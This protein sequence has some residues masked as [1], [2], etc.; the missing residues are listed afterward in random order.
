MKHL[1]KSLKLMKNGFASFK[2]QVWC[3][4]VWVLWGLSGLINKTYT[5][6]RHFLK[7]QGGRKWPKCLIFLPHG[8]PKN[9]LVDVKCCGPLFKNVLP[10]AARSTLFTKSCEHSVKMQ[11]KQT[12][13][14][15]Q[16]NRKDQLGTKFEPKG[17]HKQIIRTFPMFFLNS[18][19]H[20]LPKESLPAERP[21]PSGRGRGR[22]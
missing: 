21:G 12:G 17:V 22:V 9:E 13:R 2:W 19:G 11:P 14:T 4:H 6:S 10:T 8:G 20:E 3:I 16:T 5:L 15:A 1:Q 18:K 7:F